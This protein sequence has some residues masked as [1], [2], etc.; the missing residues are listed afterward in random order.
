M[1]SIRGVETGQRPVRPGSPTSLREANHG[2][3][4]RALQVSGAL[5]QAEIARA[6]GLAQSTVSNIVREF[7]TRGLVLVGP[8][9]RGGRSV[10]LARTAGLIV[11]VDVGHR[12]LGVCVAD[13]AY[14]VVAEQR[15]PLDEGHRA[16]DG[17][18]EVARIL[19]A[20]L[21][22]AGAG[23]DAV[24]GVGMGLPA[25]IDSRT[26]EVGA[27]SILPGW[28]GVDA[29]N[30]ASR[31]IAM[32]VAVDNDANLGALAEARWGAGVGAEH[33]AY[34]K[35]SDGVGAGLVVDGEL[36]RGRTGTAGETKGR[37]LEEMV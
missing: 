6:T 28:V 16:G 10:R 36:F 18:D 11:G 30:L 14:Q 19:D 4:L 20:L 13:L 2:R 33:L 5:S 7:S 12:H 37:E 17:M 15:V 31:R 24:V 29:A 23:R 8:G 35:L 3:V 9:P 21:A 27:P 32:P 26:G 22:A 1:A 25:P 34:L